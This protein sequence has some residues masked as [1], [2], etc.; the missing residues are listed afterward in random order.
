VVS[1]AGEPMAWLPDGHGLAAVQRQVVDE[2]LS[3]SC[4]CK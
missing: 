4:G 1:L 2:P 3:D